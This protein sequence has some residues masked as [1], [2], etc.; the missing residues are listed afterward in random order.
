LSAEPAELEAAPEDPAAK[1]ICPKCKKESWKPY[2][3]KTRNFYGTP[4]EYMVYR[5]PDGRRRTP[6]KCTVRIVG[7]P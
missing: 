1:T 3:M 5:H 6:R 4:Y 7:Q 2:I